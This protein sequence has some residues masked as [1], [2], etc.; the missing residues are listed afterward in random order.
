MALPPE[1]REWR[2]WQHWRQEIVAVAQ[3]AENFPAQRSQQRQCEGSTKVVRGK[4]S[5]TR[6]KLERFLKQNTFFCSRERTSY[7]RIGIIELT[8]K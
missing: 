2:T 1:R 5:F 4:G 8:W 3:L 7:V 6:N